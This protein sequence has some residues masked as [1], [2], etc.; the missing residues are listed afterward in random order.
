MKNYTKEEFVKAGLN[1]AAYS[2]LKMIA[3]DEKSHEKFLTKSLKGKNHSTMS[4]LRNML[5]FHLIQLL[6]PSPSS[7]ATTLSPRPTS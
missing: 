1:E 3:G 4:L 2:N 6:E 7:D 5:T